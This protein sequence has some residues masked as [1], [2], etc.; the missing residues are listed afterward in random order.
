MARPCRGSF[1]WPSP[2][3]GDDLS[4]EHQT[5]RQKIY[6]LYCGASAVRAT[7][8]PLAV[9]KRRAFLAETE[10]SVPPR[11]HLLAHQGRLLSTHL[12]SARARS[13]RIASESIPRAISQSRSEG[14][15]TG[16]LEE[17]RRTRFK[18]K[19]GRK[20]R[21]S[22]PQSP[23]T[24]YKSSIKSVPCGI[25]GPFDLQSD[26]YGSQCQFGSSLRR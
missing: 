22:R 14:G 1:S 4:A 16:R 11:T 6:R 26:E 19:G 8:V 12:C 17:G 24:N 13:R 18:R 3:P 7:E 20:V 21:L 2:Q 23:R 25:C 5:W 10:K 15:L 9:Q